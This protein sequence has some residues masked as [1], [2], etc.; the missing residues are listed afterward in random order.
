VV[1]VGTRVPAIDLRRRW[2]TLQPALDEAVARVLRSGRLLLGPETEAFEAEFAA[3]CGR[4]HAVAV[5]SG[6]EALRLSIEALGIGRGDEVVIPAFTAAPTAAAVCAANATPVL[7]DVD[8]ATAALDPSLVPAAFTERTRAIVSVHLYGR[9]APVPE[10]DVPV[11]EDAAQAHGALDPTATRGI[12]AAYSFY[13]TKNLGGIGDGGAVV[14]DDADL[15]ARV[16]LLRAHG[17]RAAYEH[18]AIAGNSRMSEI[19]AAALRLGLA[20]LSECNARRRSIVDRYRQA[21]PSMRWHAEHA[22]HVHHLCVARVPERDSF[23]A[24]MP[25][26]TAVHYP[27]AL[28]QQPAYAHLTRTPCPEA[29]AWAAE[30]V[31]IPC[32]PELTD[33]EIEAVCR[34]LR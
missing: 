14:T 31:S 17:A 28:T 1:S 10:L 11:I 21:A 27:R 19:E 29:E 34:A 23:R 32:F 15:A 26:E 5:S 3:F 4:D 24:A 8:A 18:T 9:P 12:A 13:P 16:R 7:V 2:E 33:D 22:S 25:F 20:R 6:T 30:C